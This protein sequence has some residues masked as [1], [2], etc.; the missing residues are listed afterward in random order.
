MSNITGI[1]V[2]LLVGGVVIVI[3]AIRA[4][5]MNHTAMRVEKEGNTKTPQDLESVDDSISTLVRWPISIWAVFLVAYLAIYLTPWDALSI[6]TGS[7]INHYAEKIFH[8][9]TVLTLFACALRLLN[10]S[11]AH[12]LSGQ[13]KI[14]KDFEQAVHLGFKLLKIVL[15]VVAAGALLTIFNLKELVDKLLALGAVSSIIV[16]FA[17]Q[18]TL[19]N[20]FGSSM[21]LLDRPFK[22]N[23]FISSPDKDIKGVVEY[24]G[25][26][27]TRVRDPQYGIKYIPNN[28]FTKIT[29]NNLTQSKRRKYSTVVGVR[30]E[31]LAKVPKICQDI[32]KGLGKLDTIDAS[33]PFCYAKFNGL[34]DYSVN[35]KIVCYM[36]IGKERVYD[37]FIHTVLGVVVK[38]VQK[39]KADFPFPTTTLDAHELV[40]TLKSKAIDGQ[41]EQEA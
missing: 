27:V 34:G 22:V 40:Q 12:V 28:N 31:D 13:K 7:T 38:A 17:A 11:E 23:D 37:N 33:A 30:Y 18:D 41:E 35:I 3:L 20:F 9:S 32:E 19:A 21:V 26:R 36:K 6:S 14:S 4:V 25:W 10:R 15:Y 39:N 16:G 5:W 24:I 2:V 8:A 1:D 29:I